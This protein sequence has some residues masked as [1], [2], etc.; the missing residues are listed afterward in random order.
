MKRENLIGH[1]FGRLTLIKRSRTIKNRLY[2]LCQCE[3][4]KEIE[5]LSYNIKN[6]HTKSCGCLH[7]ELII[8]HNLSHHPIYHVW[9]AMRY[10][11][12]YETCKTFKNY[13]GRGIGICP[14]WK[15]DFKIF[16]HWALCNGWAKGLR[17]DRI[18]NNGNYEP[19]NC[20]FINLKESNRNTRAIILNEEKVKDIK[21]RLKNKERSIDIANLYGVNPCLI[22][23]IKKGLT[24]QDVII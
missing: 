7:K 18:D 24:W 14:E 2:W 19:D 9:R 16:A 1:K 22:Y 10:R 23:G 6:G 13:G 3:C 17:I 5:I 20:R 21:I 15:N 12:Y 4:G 11:C 8:K